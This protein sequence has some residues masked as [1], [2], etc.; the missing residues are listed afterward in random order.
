M[1]KLII[2]AVIATAALLQSCD[3]PRR[4][5][6]KLDKYCPLCPSKDST[7]T[8]IKYRDTTITLPGETVEV[9][10]SVYCDSLGNVYS[11]RLSEQQG[12][13]TRLET[14]L[15]NNRYKSKAIVD[16]VYKTIKGNT[17]QIETTKSKTIKVKEKYI[18]GFV[19]FLAWLGGIILLIILLYFIYRVVKAR[20]TG[21]VK[22]F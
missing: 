11:I 7:V 15:R 4:L 1:K 22:F 5:Q 14:Q 9:V 6:K 19:N 13:I 8:V 18:P 12:K 20:L 17:V 16:T 2:L 10:D 21:R 3:G